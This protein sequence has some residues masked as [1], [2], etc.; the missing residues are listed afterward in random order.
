ME[1]IILQNLILA[2]L[3]GNL[4]VVRMYQS[5]LDAMDKGLPF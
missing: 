2:I 4:E 3:R 5:I 1:T